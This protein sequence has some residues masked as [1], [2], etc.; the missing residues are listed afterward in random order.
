VAEGVDIAVAETPPVTARTQQY[1]GADGR[2]RMLALREA[3][4]DEL[5][6][7][8]MGRGQILSARSSNNITELHRA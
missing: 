5:P 6:D 4:P 1:Q 2:C 8:E 3:S 7:A